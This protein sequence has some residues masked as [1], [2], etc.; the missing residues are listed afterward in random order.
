MLRKL[1]TVST[2]CV[3][4]TS[5]T[6]AQGLNNFIGSRIGS[7]YW[8]G[9]EEGKPLITINIVA[10]VNL[11]GIYHVPIDTNLAQL[12]AYAG[13]FVKEAD[14]DDIEVRRTRGRDQIE[15][16]EL[17]FNK[18]SRSSSPLPPLVDKDII[19]IPVSYAVEKTAQ[20]VGIAAGFAAVILSIMSIHNNNWR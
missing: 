11:P 1:I 4:I 8:V 15:F 13:G 17:D 14:L 9:K 20:Y 16:I 18:L 3:F 19:N 7:E 5:T 10:G 6:F 2:T 12:A